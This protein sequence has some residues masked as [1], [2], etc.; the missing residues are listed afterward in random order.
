MV[1]LGAMTVFSLSAVF[2]FPVLFLSL[3]TLYNLSCAR[4]D[5]LGSLS[6]RV[7]KKKI[8]ISINAATSQISDLRQNLKGMPKRFFSFSGISLSN[9]SFISRHELC[10]SADISS[11]NLSFIISLCELFPFITMPLLFF[12]EDQIT[13]SLLRLNAIYLCLRLFPVAVLFLYACTLR[14]HRG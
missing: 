12:Q 11:L 13:A 9:R 10:M 4:M 2:A 5:S 6:I 14:S 7:E 8:S 1:C 3:P